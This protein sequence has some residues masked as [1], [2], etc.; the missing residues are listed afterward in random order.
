MLRPSYRVF[1]KQQAPNLGAELVGVEGRVTKQALPP[2]SQSC[3][4]FHREKSYD[5]QEVR[6]HR[7]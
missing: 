1:W 7:P 4:E 3:T 5:N 6:Q 2:A